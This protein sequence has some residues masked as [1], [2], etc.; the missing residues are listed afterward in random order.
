MI[1]LLFWLSLFLSACSV[2]SS[3]DFNLQKQAQSSSVKQMEENLFE[4]INQIRKKY[5]LKPLQ[6]KPEL[7]AT[8]RAYSKLMS[9]KDFFEHKSPSG[10]NLADRLE[11][12]DL[13]YI[14]AGENL[15]MS[16]NLAEPTAKA[17]DEWMNSPR[18]K[19]NILN[20]CHK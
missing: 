11:K 6:E 4:K 10:L 9:E 14:L 2:H 17:A 3:E 16:F 5:K 15:F 12:T 13:D 1:Y 20:S 7:S 19:K 8:A 18:H